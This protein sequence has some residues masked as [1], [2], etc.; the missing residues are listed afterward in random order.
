MVRQFIL[1]LIVAAY[2]NQNA[3]NE[4]AKAMDNMSL[5]KKM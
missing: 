3:Q 2:H 1:F 4:Y 5:F